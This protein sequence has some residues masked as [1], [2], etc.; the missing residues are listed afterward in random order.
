[1]AFIPITTP[2]TITISTTLAPADINTYYQF[3]VDT[4]GASSNANS[5][6][7]AGVKADIA[8]QMSKAYYGVEASMTARTLAAA[9]ASTSPAI[10]VFTVL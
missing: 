3:L 10:R 6:V 9:V 1:M 7:V 8:T 4:Q 5:L 2:V